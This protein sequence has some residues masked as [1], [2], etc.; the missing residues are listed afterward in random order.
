MSNKIKKSIIIGLVMSFFSF[1][2]VFA[3]TKS[4]FNVQ[5]L[6]T[7]GQNEIIYLINENG[8]LIKL[9]KG[10]EDIVPD[11]LPEL[12]SL[13]INEN[14][15]IALTEDNKIISSIDLRISDETKVSKIDGKFLLTTDGRVLSE[16]QKTS[17]F[18]ES[19]KN[20][21]DIKALSDKVVLIYEQDDTVSIVGDGTNGISVIRGLTNV[22][23]AVIYQDN[24]LLI[25]KKDG[26]VVG[27]GDGYEKISSKVELILNAKKFI[28]EDENLY[29]VTFDNKAIPIFEKDFKAPSEYL[30]NVENIVI[31][32][33]S[34]GESVLYKSYFITTDG[35]LFYHIQSDNEISDFNEQKIEYMNTFENVKMVYESGYLTIVLHRDGSITIPYNIHHELNGVTGVK[36]V[37]LKNQSYVV[38]FEDGQVVTSLE[39]FILN[40]KENF[41]QNE[42]D[43]TL[44]S[45]LNG[46]FLNILNKD[47]SEEEFEFLKYSITNSKEE[48]EKFIRSIC[49]DRKFL[50][51]DYSYEEII[52]NLYKSILNTVPSEDEYRHMNVMIIDKMVEESKNKDE[53][54]NEI[55]NYIFENPIF[56]DIFNK[57]TQM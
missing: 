52:N 38:Y 3:Q 14:D 19:F 21:K 4:N 45:Y 29:V 30:S 49:L 8:E 2:V 47:F 51:F 25:I 27:L 48:F 35:K 55:L 36:D 7:H 10:M 50:M 20:V 24:V 28:K 33:F 16:N 23:E 53:I 57:I 42:E 34:S 54:V 9:N 22:I 41:F 1:I 17:K 39:N 18:L 44:Y 11:D 43:M 46:I 12:L 26:R 6:N 32:R 31:D 56:E 40:K 13:S 5:I 37:V 15:F